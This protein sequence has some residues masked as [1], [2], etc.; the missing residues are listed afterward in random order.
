M[1]GFLAVYRKELYSLFASPIFYAVAFVFLLLAGYFFYSS[2]AY[3]SLVSFQAGQNPLVAQ[4]L[5]V[6]DMVLRPFFLD[7]TLV[8]LLVA[9]LLTMR[10][11]AE[12]RKS[13]TMELLFTYPVKD[14]A[15]VL[16][17]F[18][19]V[20]TVFAAILLGTF[21]GLLLLD[22][23]ADP[24]WKVVFC[25][26]LGF[27]LVGSAFMSLGLFASSLSRNQIVAGVL[28]FGL[29]LLFWIVGW[30]GSLAGPL[31]WLLEYL[32]IM[33]RFDSFSKGVLDSRD[34]IFYV[35]FIVLFLFLTE[36]Q[37]ESYRWR[38]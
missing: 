36:R 11:Y 10:L 37:I 34:V 33:E 21:P 22:Y 1:K 5:N 31:E 4:R 38:G 35:L 18:A 3:F 14:R 19:G 26:Y 30:M 6:T 17:K 16:A 12:E 20:M 2:V 28:S 23:V 13:G 15:A 9:P 7:L 8:F 29:L 32:S 27:F 25:A 24:N